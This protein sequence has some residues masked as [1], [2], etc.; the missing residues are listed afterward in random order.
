LLLKIIGAW[1]RQNPKENQMDTLVSIRVFC[2]V[3]EHKSFTAAAERLGMSAAMTS[4]HVMRLE[5]RLATRLLNRTS[6]HVSLTESGALYF[7]QVRQMMDGLDE[8]EAAIGQAAVAPKGRLRLSVPVWMANPPFASL[9]ADYRVRY[10]DVTLEVELSGRLVNLVEEGFDLALRVTADPDPGLVA[11]SVADAPFY[12][13]ASNE[14]LDSRGRPAS[15]DELTGAP[16]LAYSLVHGDGAVPL[17]TD[18]GRRTIKFNP[19]LQSGNE[20]L[21]HYACLQGMGFA[22]LPKLLISD[23]LAAGRLERVLPET[24]FFAGRL[25]AVYPNRKYLSAKVRSFLDFIA[26]DPR[27]K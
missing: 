15:L 8:L 27:L 23:D 19:V 3:A 12:F 20:T 6:R 16:L 14:F 10:P 24:L 17:D 26:R 11:R 4:K 21:M 9:L 22:F 13:V 2:A 1:E 18:Q 7:E 5:E 25:L